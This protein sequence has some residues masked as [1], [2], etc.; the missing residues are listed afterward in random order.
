MIVID[1]P[2]YNG[3]VK[4]RCV[5]IADFRL[6]NESLDVDIKINHKKVNGELVYPNLYTMNKYEIAKYP[7]QIIKNNIIL[8]LVPIEDLKLKRSLV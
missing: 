7:K 4:K 2:I 6:R 5:G 1:K 8:Y 3:N